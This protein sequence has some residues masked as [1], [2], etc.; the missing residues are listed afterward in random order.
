M[1]NQLRIRAYYEAKS[2]LGSQ[3]T[4]LG[5]RHWSEFSEE[6][7]DQLVRYIFG[8]NQDDVFWSLVNWFKTAGTHTSTWS[9]SVEPE[10]EKAGVRSRDAEAR[11][12][13]IKKG[14]NY[15]CEQNLKLTDA[16]ILLDEA[17]RERLKT[18]GAKDLPLG[19][20]LVT[21]LREAIKDCEAVILSMIKRGHP[22]VYDYLISFLLAVFK[23]VL[24]DIPPTG[25]L[26]NSFRILAQEVFSAC[27]Y[28]EGSDTKVSA[29]GLLSRV[30]KIT[31]SEQVLFEYSEQSNSFV[32]T[33]A[34]KAEDRQ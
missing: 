15:F 18:L 24:P 4:D 17:F 16:L 34:M 21:E 6:V 11:L 33:E 29:G 30:E 19:C 32:P 23:H 8:E 2:L 10:G 12:K 3:L 26:S 7:V 9:V 14:I 1:S 28:Y 20:F 27:F 5:S 31:Q 13:G 22:R 25:E